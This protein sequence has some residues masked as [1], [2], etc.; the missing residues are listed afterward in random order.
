MKKK[1]S[2]VFVILLS[3]TSFSIFTWAYQEE[4]T[5]DNYLD[6]LKIISCDDPV[7]ANQ[8]CKISVEISAFTPVLLHIEFKGRFDWGDWIFKT[9]TFE[10]ETGSETITAEFEIP[11]KTL[12]EPTC[13]YLYYVYVTFPESSWSPDVWGLVQEVRVESP[14]QLEY[15]EILSLL[16]HIKWKVISSSLPEET[17]EHLILKLD[18][19][20]E[21]VDVAS[22]TGNI[23]FYSR[24]FLLFTQSKQDICKNLDST[25]SLLESLVEIIEIK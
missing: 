17:K 13:D 16:N 21:L 6:T 3:L 11:L 7:V 1:F 22:L 20:D 23:D 18:G 4:W 12:F 5:H 9:C 8:E 19:I 25:E 15:E 2:L 10:L 24:I 14:D